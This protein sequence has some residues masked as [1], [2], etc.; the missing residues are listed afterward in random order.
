MHKKV[1]NFEPSEKAKVIRALRE[2]NGWSQTELAQKSGFSRGTIQNIESGRH[3][4]LD[5]TLSRVMQALQEGMRNAGE[6]DAV[7]KSFQEENLENLIDQAKQVLR[8]TEDNPY[9]RALIENIK[10]FFHAVIS[11]NDREPR[12]QI[13]GPPESG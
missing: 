4:Q 9:R 12:P 2:Q 10:A 5:K 13:T 11:E 6:R 8:Q 1:K 7:K 3:G